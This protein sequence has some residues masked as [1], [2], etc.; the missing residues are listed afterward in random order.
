MDVA[1]VLIELY[2]RIPEHVRDAVS[3]LTPEQ[4]VTP[5]GQ[6]ANPVGWIV[7][8]LTRVQDAHLAEVRDSEQV[9][10]TG[11][12]APRFGMEPDP[13]NTGF[14]HSP[15]DVAAVRPDGADALVGYYDAVA[16]RTREF[17]RGVTP[18]DLG[19]VVDAAWDPPVTLGVRLVSVADDD[20]Q[21]AGQAKYVR[22]FLSSAAPLRAV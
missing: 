7:W 3:G 10:V 2:D 12:W 6:G 19:Q 18:A 22:G 14:G 16:A 11:G 17:L 9:W 21:H 15:A 5:P 13:D 8:H 20:I 4:L 1:E